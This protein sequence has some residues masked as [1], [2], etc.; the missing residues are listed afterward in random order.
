MVCVSLSQI[1]VSVPY[2]CSSS[3]GKCDIVLTGI[4]VCISQC[5]YCISDPSR[6]FVLSSEKTLIIP[7]QFLEHAPPGACVLIVCQCLCPDV[8]HA[9]PVD[10]ITPW[11]FLSAIKSMITSSYWPLECFSSSLLVSLT[12]TVNVINACVENGIQ[13]LVYTSSMEVVGPN[14]KGDPFIRQSFTSQTSVSPLGFRCFFSS[15]H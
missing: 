6:M 15:F 2:F 10:R 14:V 4:V 13:Y 1:W 7:G 9:L 12:G 5:N 3:L 8:L 11:P